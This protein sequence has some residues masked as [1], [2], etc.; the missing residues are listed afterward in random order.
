MFIQGFLSA[1]GSA[2]HIRVSV[3]LSSTVLAEEHWSLPITTS[4]RVHV[5]AGEW[6]SHRVIG[7]FCVGIWV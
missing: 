6:E 1:E 3:H 7:Q 4:P 2:K 5:P